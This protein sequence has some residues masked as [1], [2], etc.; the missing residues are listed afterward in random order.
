[1]SAFV[2]MSMCASVSPSASQEDESYI[3][4]VAALCSET[5]CECVKGSVGGVWVCR[6][7]YVSVCLLRKYEYACVVCA[8]L[9][10]CVVRVCVCACAR[11]CLVC[12]FLVR[13]CNE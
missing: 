7:Y 2:S 12:I 5:D 4:E 6:V 1:M 13:L 3:S 9:I 10:V 8:D 11:I